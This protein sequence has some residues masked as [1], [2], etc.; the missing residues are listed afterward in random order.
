MSTQESLALL[1]DPPVMSRPEREILTALLGNESLVKR[2]FTF[3]GGEEHFISYAL[4]LAEENFPVPHK[5][6]ETVIATGWV[7]RHEGAK[8]AGLCFET[9]RLNDRGR[10]ALRAALVEQ[11][12]KT[13]GRQAI[14]REEI[15]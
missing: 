11:V 4:M 7:D 13:V 1:T 10:E 9:F 6:A 2:A 5:A 8:L 3:N 15:E 12:L 14:Q